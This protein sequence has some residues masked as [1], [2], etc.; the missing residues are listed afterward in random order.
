MLAHDRICHQKVFV[1]TLPPKDRD[2]IVPTVDIYVIPLPV[3]LNQVPQMAP[4]ALANHE[5]WDPHSIHQHFPGHSVALAHRI[6][7]HQRPVGGPR[8]LGFG[9]TQINRRI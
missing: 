8:L 5:T 6:P 7:G 9:L 2:N 1:H 4:V 3:Q